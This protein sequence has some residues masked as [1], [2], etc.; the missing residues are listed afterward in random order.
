MKKSKPNILMLLTD[1]Q[2]FDTICAAGFGHVH[3]PNLDRLV[4]RGCVYTQAYSSSPACM[5]ARHDL[6]TGVSARHH[7]LWVNADKTMQDYSLA[8]LPRMLTESGYQTM[9]IGKMHYFP[10]REHHGW[11]HMTLMEE[12]PQSREDDEYLDYLSRVGYGHIT[13]PHGVRQMFYHSPQVSPIPEE[14]HGTAWVARQTAKA[15]RTERKEPFF[16]LAGWIDPHPPYSIPEKYIEQYKDAVLPEPSPRPDSDERQYPLAGDCD[17]PDAHQLQRLREA[18]F[19]SCT[20][21]DRW[22]GEVLDAL[23]ESGQIDN[24]YIIFTSD[25]GEMLGDRQAYQKFSPYEGSARTPL[26]VCGPNVEPGSTCSAPVT[27]WD[28]AATVADLSGTVPPESGPEWV[29]RSLLS[30]LNEDRVVCLHHG[31]DPD[32]FSPQMNRFVASVGCNHKFVHYYNGGDEEFYDLQADPQEQNNLLKGDLSAEQT[33]LAAK[34]KQACIGFERDH[35]QAARVKENQFVDD[36]YSVPMTNIGRYFVARFGQNPVWLTY[37]SEKDYDHVIHELTA[38]LDQDGIFVPVSNDWKN[39]AR[40][41]WE[42][43]GGDP[44]LMEGFIE[45]MEERTCGAI[46]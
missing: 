2:R 6:L 38:C 39:E 42:R 29:G 40:Q 17:V 14:H 15:I 27:T 24:T 9:A 21:V 18:Y 25:H 46:A 16:I 32:G 37:R 1:Q 28:I 44:G 13:S 43:L 22:I 23:E 45:K 10:V 19:A 41:A 34:L 4:K 35:G 33:A 7:G 20:F 36:P 12:I 5:P 30:D 8:T 11:S 31:G 26:I 3:T